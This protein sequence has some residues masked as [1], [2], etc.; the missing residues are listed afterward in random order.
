MLPRKLPFS[1]NQSKAAS[2]RN[3]FPSRRHIRKVALHSGQSCSVA[4]SKSPPWRHASVPTSESSATR[5]NIQISRTRIQG[6]PTF[7]KSTPRQ[8][9]CVIGF[10][11]V[12]LSTGS[13][14]AGSIRLLTV[15]WGKWRDRSSIT[16][17]PQATPADGAPPTPPPA[18]APKPAVTPAKQ[19]PTDRQLPSRSFRPSPEPAADQSPPAMKYFHPP[20][21]CRPKDLH[22]IP[23]P[24]TRI[25]QAS[26]ATF[27][28]REH[29]ANR[30]QTTP[31]N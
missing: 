26:H 4:G 13:S 27:S 14:A 29:H 18:F 6:G 11:S 8:I 17:S 16:S 31:R 12:V 10:S 19:T 20:V 3:K 30:N 2:G 24:S 1:L 9:L 21:P 5:L 15:R 28:M 7:S 25:P 22:A 23:P